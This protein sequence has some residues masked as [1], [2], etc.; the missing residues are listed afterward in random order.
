M[1]LDFY[2][3]EC[4]N[5]I[6]YGKRFLITNTKQVAIIPTNDIEISKKLNPDEKLGDKAFN[7]KYWDLVTEPYDLSH[8]IAESSEEEDEE[9]ESESND[10]MDGDSLDGEYSD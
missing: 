5:K 6:D 4:F 2:R 1:R 10:L 3:P 9:T 7:K 8:E